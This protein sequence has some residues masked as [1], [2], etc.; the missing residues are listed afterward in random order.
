VNSRIDHPSLGPL[1]VFDPTDEHTPLGELPVH[2]QGSLAL[3]VAPAAGALL[4]MP[5][6]PASAHAIERT[7]DGQLAPNGALTATVREQ[8]LGAFGTATRASYVALGPAS[9][10]TTVE[11]RLAAALP[12]VQIRSLDV[13]N[14]SAS[15]FT[16]VATTEA[17][18]YAQHQAG[19]LLLPMPF[20]TD[21]RLQFPGVAARRTPL[22]LEPRLVRE[23]IR[24]QVPAGYVVDEL[25]KPVTIEG[26]F[27]TYAIS[28][29]VD[30]AHLVATR[31]LEVPAQT[32]AR[33]RYDEVR[34]FFSRV[35]ASDVSPVVLAKKP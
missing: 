31:R 15:A 4:R 12:R 2:E 22:R 29:R 3:I 7:I 10:R 28:Y 14:E 18:A 30:G 26:E 19:L 9:F 21:D 32:V 24:L 35:R 33:E 27:G 17:G 16:L 13:E 23:T 8:F 20:H 5:L 34:G 25:P 6:S 1:L 11:R